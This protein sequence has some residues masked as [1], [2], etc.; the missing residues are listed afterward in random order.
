MSPCERGF[1][2]RFYGAALLNIKSYLADVLCLPQECLEKDATLLWTELDG[3]DGFK[4][5][6]VST[7]VCIGG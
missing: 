7:T 4:H 2:I 6:K 5:M 3:K 1:P